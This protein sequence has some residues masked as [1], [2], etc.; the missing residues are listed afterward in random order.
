MR[1]FRD[2]FGC[3]AEITETRHGEYRLTTWTPQGIPVINKVYG[4]YRGARI[5]MGR[6]SDGWKEVS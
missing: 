5:A 2:F 4:T 1:R 3:T 6:M